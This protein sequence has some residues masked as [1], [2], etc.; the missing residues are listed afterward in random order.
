MRRKYKLRQNKD[1]EN[2]KDKKRQETK[3]EKEKK[4]RQKRKEKNKKDKKDEK[5]RKK[6]NNTKGQK[7]KNAMPKFRTTFQKGASLNSV[8][9]NYVSRPKPKSCR[10]VFVIY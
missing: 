5:E 4:Q 2:K 10:K 3:E 6:T 7:D 1:K 8:M 9:S